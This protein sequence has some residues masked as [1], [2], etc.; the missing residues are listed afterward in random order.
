MCVD[1]EKAVEGLVSTPIIVWNGSTAFIV[2]ERQIVTDTPPTEAAK[3][4][5]ATYYIFNMQY[6]Q[7]CKNFGLLLEI[8]LL[9]KVPVRVPPKCCTVLSALKSTQVE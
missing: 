5:L 1:V 3:A 4:L 8:L 2:A 6:P 7:G 9:D